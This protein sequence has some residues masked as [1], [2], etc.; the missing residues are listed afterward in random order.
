[1]LPSA[2]IKS[3]I[4]F[5]LSVPV[6]LK[7]RHPQNE[8]NRSSTLGPLDLNHMDI[9]RSV[10]T[11]RISSRFLLTAVWILFFNPLTLS[12]LGLSVPLSNLGGGG[13]GIRLSSITPDSFDGFQ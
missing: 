3:C 7:L 10:F 2:H 9:L 11:S 13:G 1:M 6:V 12:N 4:Y 5:S 8:Q